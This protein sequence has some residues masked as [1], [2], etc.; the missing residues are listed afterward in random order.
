MVFAVLGRR[1]ASQGLPLGS[2]WF[3]ACSWRD[4]DSFAAYL[5]GFRRVPGRAMIRLQAKPLRKEG[6]GSALK[7]QS[8]LKY[9]APRARVWRRVTPMAGDAPGLKHFR[10]PTCFVIAGDVRDVNKS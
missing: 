7:E 6:F 1:E 8:Y 4:L 10:K 9:R 2:F 5:Y 3:P